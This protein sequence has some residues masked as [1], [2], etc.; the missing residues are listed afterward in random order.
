M[1]VIEENLFSLKNDI[2]K[3]TN[4]E[5]DRR[6]FRY[7]Y[8]TVVNNII[9][10]LF[11]DGKIVNGNYN[12]A[13][14][15][16]D[17]DYIRE[18]FL[19]KCFTFKEQN[20]FFKTQDMNLDDKRCDLIN[21]CLWV[22]TIL[23]L[24]Y[25]GHGIDYSDLLQEGSLGISDAIYDYGKTTYSFSRSVIIKVDEMLKKYIMNNGKY[26]NIS[27]RQC[28][29]LLE[30]ADIDEN[31]L[32]LYGHEVPDV[33]YADYLNIPSDF[34]EKLKIRSYGSLD[35]NNIDD[36]LY[37]H[38]TEIGFVNV[39]EEALG[40]Y[41]YEDI[42]EACKSSLNE[43]EKFIIFHYFGLNDCKP[44][45]YEEIA[46]NLGISKVRVSQIVN[47]SLVKIKARYKRIINKRKCLLSISDIKRLRKEKIHF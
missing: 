20:I 1:D 43:R 45:N 39:E 22:P 9:E 11:G 40:R 47:T 44:M 16:A 41:N 8:V 13:L 24:K 19:G 26:G 36:E 10:L 3:L 33:Y 18:I 28:E 37:S 6:N 42:I 15:E 23:S 38:R 31:I 46:S 27:K 25:I 32:A 35:I 34:F 21:G 14:N 29:I 4:L 17:I 7:N 5:N 12:E 30:L 2:I